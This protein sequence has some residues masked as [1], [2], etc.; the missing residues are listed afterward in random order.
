MKKVKVYAYN[1]CD[2]CRKALKFLDGKKIPYEA[3]DIT[4]QAPTKKE[5]ETMLAQVGDL[6]KLFNTSGVV[7][8]EMKL[9]EKLPTMSKTEALHLLSSN[10]R[11]VKRPFLLADSIALVGFREPEWRA[12]F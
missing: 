4:E 9:S 2:T 12:V 3:L 8:K 6:K 5:L 7:Y 11:L 10:G 1:K